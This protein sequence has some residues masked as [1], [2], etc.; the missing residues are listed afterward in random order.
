MKI[1]VTGSHFTPAQAVIEKLLKLPDMEIVYIGRKYARDDDKVLS[2]ESKILPK[3]G[4]KFIPIIAGKFNRFFSIQTI[5]SFLKTPV[6]FVQSF[7][8]VVKEQPD[9]ILS[10]GGFTGMPV[11]VCGWFLSVPSII[12]EQG[13]KMGLSNSVSSLFADK[14]AVSF[15]N[16]KPP[17]FAEDKVI[18]TGNPVRSEILDE[19]ISPDPEIKNFIEKA[20]NKPLILITAGNQG[21][22]KINLMVE[23][24]LPELT[25]DFALIHQT[26]ESKYDDF[27]NLKKN[28]SE[29]YLVKKWIDGRDLSY[30]LESVDLV[31][32][33]G[34]INTLTELAL[35]STPALIVPI[36]V[37]SEQRN[38]A[39][40]FSKLGMGEVLE[41]KKL[42]PDLFFEKI[43]QMLKRKAA[44]KNSAKNPKSA[45][46]LGAADKLVQEILLFKN[47]QDTY[48]LDLKG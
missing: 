9:L 18:V 23:D 3:L 29:N 27:S 38:N 25:E 1:V 21:S 22:H 41:D 37:G 19:N 47:S 43:K 12:H 13:L 8:Y 5:I 34:G 17:F 35:K 36:P 26:G 14:L 48:N 39:L 7:Y 11:V 32:C 15:E 44:L 33:R 20:K 2:A 4:I 42:T 30:I 10:F 46:I 28:I 40:Y 31:V 16:F 24:K 45:I 6:G